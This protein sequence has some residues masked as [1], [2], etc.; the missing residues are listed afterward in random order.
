M[1]QT[2]PGARQ[3]PRGQRPVR[4]LP[5]EPCWPGSSLRVPEECSRVDSDGSLPSCPRVPG[6]VLST[7]QLL[8]F[9]PSAL[10]ALT[11]RV[12]ETVLFP[13]SKGQSQDQ[14]RPAGCRARAGSALGQNHKP[15]SGRRP[16]GRGQ[17]SSGL[18]LQPKACCAPGNLPPPP[19][20][21]ESGPAGL[22]RL[23]RSGASWGRRARPGSLHVALTPRPRKAH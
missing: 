12:T 8:A 10:P 18:R 1:I 3:K 14:V 19:L 22:C 11:N 13:A 23:H 15:S 16:A 4:L 5:E 17:S 2:I 7:P 21:R 6:P 20:G 9:I